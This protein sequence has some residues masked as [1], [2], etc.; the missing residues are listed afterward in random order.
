VLLS[1]AKRW[2]Q[3]PRPFIGIHSS[4]SFLA[5]QAPQRASQARQGLARRRKP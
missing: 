4:L 1:R 3:L 5:W 2:F